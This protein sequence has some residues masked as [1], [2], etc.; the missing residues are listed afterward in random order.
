GTGGAVTG[1]STTG[2]PG[3]HGGDA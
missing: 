1:V 3:G 2:G